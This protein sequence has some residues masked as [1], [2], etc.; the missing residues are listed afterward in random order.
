MKDTVLVIVDLCKNN[1]LML[2]HC[3]DR[4]SVVRCMPWWP[5]GMV[6]WLATFSGL[7]I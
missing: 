4:L 2:V 6:A 1:C 5:A 7:G 3:I